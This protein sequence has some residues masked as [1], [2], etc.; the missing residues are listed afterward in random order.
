MLEVRASISNTC[1]NLSIIT[2]GCDSKSPTPIDLHT[3]CATCLGCLEI[4]VGTSV[5]SDVRI[6]AARGDL[7]CPT[8]VDK[9]N[10]VGGGTQTHV[11]AVSVSGGSIFVR[12]TDK[13]EGWAFNLRIKCTPGLPICENKRART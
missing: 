13:S 4:T 10:W 8:I 11:F 9:T 3:S 2:S 6:Q 12:R 5:F 7:I 1:R